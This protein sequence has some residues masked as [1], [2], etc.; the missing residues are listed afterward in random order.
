M[1]IDLNML[2]LCVFEKTN[3]CNENLLLKDIKDPSGG[4][5][6]NATPERQTI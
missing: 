1:D 3:V 2:S 5:H 6:L 4:K